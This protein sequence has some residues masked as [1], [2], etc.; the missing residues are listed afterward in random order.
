[1][2]ILKNEVSRFFA[3]GFAGGAALVMATMG[4][5]G[6]GDGSDLARG[7]VPQAEAAAAQ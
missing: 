3:L 6:L 5:G 7:L 2:S 4:L 1:M